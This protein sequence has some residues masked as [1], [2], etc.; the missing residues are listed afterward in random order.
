MK[1]LKHLFLLFL[2]SSCNGFNEN[3]FY[4]KCAKVLERSTNQEEKSIKNTYKKLWLEVAENGNKPADVVVHKTALGF[5]TVFENKRKQLASYKS[6]HETEASLTVFLDS[7]YSTKLSKEEKIKDCREEV[8]NIFSLKNMNSD[9]KKSFLI[10]KIVGLE[11]EIIGSLA[12]QVG[13]SYCGFTIVSP[14]ILWE[15]DTVSA[16]ES[17]KGKVFMYSS[18]NQLPYMINKVEINKVPVE[19]KK[20]YQYEFAI[21]PPKSVVFNENGES[22]QEW[23]GKIYYT[24]SQTLEDSIF[25]IQGKYIIQ[26][27]CK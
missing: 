24:N 22:L 19:L 5:Y 10:N 16:G 13:S 1:L 26:K 11:K 18:R 15:K 20:H 21:A 17:L 6:I 4:T 14:F 8:K 7:I 3:D 12:V 9:L 27:F 23:E 25:T 2:L